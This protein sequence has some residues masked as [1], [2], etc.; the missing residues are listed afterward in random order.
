[1]GIF[2]RMHNKQ[3]IIIL[4]ILCLVVLQPYCFGEKICNAASSIT[5]MTAAEMRD[6]AKIKAIWAGMRA[7]LKAKDINRA[8]SYIS[9]DAKDTY[10]YNFNL[11]K[12]HIDELSSTLGEIELDE[13]REGV[14]DYNMLGEYEGE[15]FNGLVRFVKDGTGNWRINFF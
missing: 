13:F 5:A 14:A 1:M 7:A 8:L 3:M 9:E 6:D 10:E 15:T 4:S 2:I 12:D 11:L